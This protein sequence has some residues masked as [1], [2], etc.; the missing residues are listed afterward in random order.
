MPGYVRFWSATT[1]S[2][3][4]TYVT[5]LG[6]QTL[7]ILTLGASAFELGLLNAARWLPYLL[8]GLIV[9]VLVDR[10]RRKPLLVA[11]DLGRAVL[12][13]A[14]PALHL[15]GAL[16]MPALLVFVFA[17][18]VLSLVFDAAD[19]S[20]VPRL[21][22]RQAL[23]VANARLQQADAVA[24]TAGPLL[25][26]GLIKVIGAPLAILVDAVSY[27]VS[28][29]LLATIRVQEPPPQPAEHRNLLGELR[30]GLAWVYHHR[31]LAP[32]ALTSHAWFLVNSLL[33]TAFTAYALDPRGLDLGAFGLS[34]ALACGGVAAVL[35]GS[36]SGWAE[37][38]LDAGPTIV[39]CHAV[40]PFAW[41]LVPLASPSTAL[42]LVSLS[43]FVFWL[44]MGMMGPIEMSYRQSVTPDGLQARMNTTIRSLNRAAIVAGAPLGG[45]L[46]V[47]F[48]YGTALWA[49]VI[50]FALVAL[51]LGLSPFRT[52]SRAEAEI[53]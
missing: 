26:G 27:L 25:A 15:A 52:A 22:P 10:L 13:M 33:G 50:G 41:L 32:M 3:F 42:V 6:L 48:G 1:I 2:V 28:G 34:V 47:T 39:V 37:R 4:G 31:T 16:T 11:T 38:R 24:Q 7:V 14:I 43:Q 35:G 36:L 8:F 21:V 23:T 29:L 51:A 20:F 12:L 19:Q 18:G 30:E 46:A 40:I 49:G 17:V 9:G 45:W 5:A 53:H 44:V